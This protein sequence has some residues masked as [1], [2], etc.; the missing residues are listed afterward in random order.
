M[1]EARARRDLV[2]GEIAAG[3]NPRILLDEL[4][5]APPVAKTFALGARVP[6]EPDRPRERRRARNSVAHRADDADIGDVDPNRITPS[7]SPTWVASLHLKAVERRRYIDTLRAVLD[8]AGVDPN[9]ARDPPRPLPKEERVE[10]EPP[11]DARS[12]RS[13]GTAAASGGS[14]YERSPRPGCASASCTPSNGAT[15]TRPG[16]G[17]ASAAARPGRAAMGRRPART[18]DRGRSGDAA[19]RSHARAARVPRRDAGRS[20]TSCAR[21]CKSAGIALYSP[22]DLRH[23]YA[24]VQVARGVPVTNVTAQL[25]HNRKSLTLDTY[26]HVL[27]D[28]GID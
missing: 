15:S 12:R 6:R 23:R 14:R 22:H 27:L 16:H 13:L 26:S 11:S 4:R 5:A 10:I 19:R 24:S 17:S 18:H 9:P 21:A 20:R 8:Y 1:K 3:R 7:M 2:A 25:G 28:E